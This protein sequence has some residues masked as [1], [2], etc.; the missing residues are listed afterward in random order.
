MPGFIDRLRGRLAG[1]LPGEEAQF[2]MAPVTRLRTQEALAKA[3][4]WR[5]GAVLLYLYPGQDDWR[6]VLMKRP[7]YDGAHGGQISIP[8]GA[9]EPGEGHAQAALREFAEETGVRV[10]RQQ[11]LGGL[12]ELFIPTSRFLVKPFVAYGAQ[13]PIFQPD[14]IEVEAIIELA[15]PALLSDASVERGRV[16]LGTGTW[17]ET[18]YFAVE[19]HRVWG[20]TAMI[21]SEFRELLRGLQ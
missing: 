3:S 12:S 11:L 17:V 18:P 9:L 4:Q 10:D 2:R 16:R 6:T 8:G 1:Q 15:L 13:R 21:L 14:A 7:E 5:Q 19:G 20:A